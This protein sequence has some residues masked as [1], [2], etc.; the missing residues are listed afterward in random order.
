MSAEFSTADGTIRLFGHGNPPWDAGETLVQV[1]TEGGIIPCPG[2]A[3]ARANVGQKDFFVPHSS[4]AWPRPVWYTFH[5]RGAGEAVVL[6]S[7]PA[8][9][10][11]TTVPVNVTPEAA[12]RVAE[13][14]LN[15]EFRQLIEHILQ[16]VSGLRHV[17]VDVSLPYDTGEDVGIGVE[18]WRSE[19]SFQKD[20]PT[21]SALIKWIVS[22]FPP[23]VFRYFATVFFFEP[24][25]EG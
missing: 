2:G 19:S 20:D 3:A 18:I 6:T 15:A 7:E 25:H 5:R 8:M 11:P 12:A 24:A 1:P 16:T 21:W 17:D 13:L 22:A 9:N 4:A 23:D 10:A 14:G